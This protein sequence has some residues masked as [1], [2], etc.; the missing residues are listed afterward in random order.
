MVEDF[1]WWAI[2]IVALVIFTLYGIEGIGSQ[3]EDPFGYDRNDIKMDAICQDSDIETSVILAEWKRVAAYAAAQWDERLQ[4]QKTSQSPIDS[5][6]R[7][8]NTLQ[9]SSS[10]RAA[11]HAASD[12]HQDHPPQG[13]RQ[14]VP[15]EMFI[16]FRR[17]HDA[18][19]ST[20]HT[21]LQS[22]QASAID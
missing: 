14:Y 22:R 13:S 18:A 12:H 15:P 10:D 8:Q 4:T 20:P 9:G 1:G 21:Q 6:Y 19:D 2:P 7:V 16:R 11:V 3:L 17:Q 5:P